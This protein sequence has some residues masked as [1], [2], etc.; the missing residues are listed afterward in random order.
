MVNYTSIP[1]NIVKVRNRGIACFTSKKDINI[2]EKVVSS[3]GDEW[4]RFYD[5]DEDEIDRIANDYFD[6][7]NTKEIKR[8]AYAIDLG[9]GCGRWT[10]Y[11]A[12]K[13]GFIEAVDP[14]ESIFIADHLLNEHENVRL[15]QASIGNLPFPDETFDFGMSIGVLHHIPDTRKALGD[16]V[17]KIKRGGFFYLYLYQDLSDKSGT[18]HFLF[19]V[20]TF[21]RG[22]ICR[23]PKRAKEF[24]CD[25]IAVT[26]YYPVTRTAALFNYL[27]FNKI[28]S[29]I[30]LNYY[31]DKSFFVLRN[32]ALDRFGTS[33]EQRFSKKKIYEMM[34][35]VGLTEIVFSEKAPFWHAIGKKDTTANL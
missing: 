1:T 3:F 32:D 22:L 28:G 8:D 7:L 4:T 24:V 19:S 11:L 6:I 33:L 14:S 20:V 16:C 13:V 21:F 31:K 17:K 35:D 23:L 10:K 15:T 12:S 25:I 30:P 26:V 29:A 18:T 34:R 9:C 2:D 27:G 5:F